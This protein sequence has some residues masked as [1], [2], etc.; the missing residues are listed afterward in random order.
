[1]GEVKVQGHIEAFIWW[2]D[3]CNHEDDIGW[4]G[5]YK[6]SPNIIISNFF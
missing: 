2:Q 1:M 6:E 4:S 3:I 5:A